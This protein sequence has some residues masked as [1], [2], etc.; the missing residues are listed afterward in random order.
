MVDAG[1][2]LL[3][4]CSICHLEFISE[5][6]LKKHV[7]SAHPEV[8][9]RGGK[10][11]VIMRNGPSGGLNDGGY[12]RGDVM[13]GLTPDGM[14][15]LT[16]DFDAD[17]GF[18]G[19]EEAGP[20]GAYIVPELQ[21]GDDNTQSL[22]CGQC[23]VSFKHRKYLMA[24]IRK[25]HPDRRYVCSACPAMFK[26]NSDLLNHHRDFHANLKIKC[27][28]CNMNYKSA[29]GLH[30]HLKTMHPDSPALKDFNSSPFD[31]ELNENGGD[32]GPGR[33]LDL[34]SQAQKAVALAAAPNI[35]PKTTTMVLGPSRPS[36]GESV[37]AGGTYE[38]EHPVNHLGNDLKND[39][40]RG[41]DRES[42]PNRL[43][44]MADVKEERFLDST[45]EDE[46]M[47]DLEDRAYPMPNLA[48]FRSAAA[49]RSD[50]S[51]LDPVINGAPSTLML[52]SLLTGGVVTG[53]TGVTRVGG[54]P[55]TL[56]AGTG[57]D[58][59]EPGNEK[60]VMKAIERLKCPDCPFI[61]SVALIF[62]EHN[63]MHRKLTEFRCPHCSYSSPIREELVQHQLLHFGSLLLASAGPTLG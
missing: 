29:K 13:P 33:D 60:L 40:L 8:A 38:L 39:A 2:V 37:F 17:D 26:S 45:H 15:G 6:G 11:V 27:P 57:S 9:A 62:N 22:F 51:L 52:R 14:A 44:K 55:P 59:E 4:N 12:L 42:S 63:K 41:L 36:F 48:G 30:A 28:H 32:F 18:E 21:Y 43:D 50:G 3:L 46:D 56:D 16:P 58:Q 23:N 20:D 47:D 5:E 24:H 49:A 34:T 25:K 31:S 1:G 10:L 54:T 61:T 35:T 53:V 19:A 7:D